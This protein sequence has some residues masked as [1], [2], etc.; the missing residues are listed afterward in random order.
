V[1]LV[2]KG[3]CVDAKKINH[4]I[5]QV[6]M[7]QKISF[8]VNQTDINDAKNDVAVITSRVAKIDYDQQ[9]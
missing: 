3:V 8:T 4:I 6:Q 2:K 1:K 9:P 7:D 5:Q